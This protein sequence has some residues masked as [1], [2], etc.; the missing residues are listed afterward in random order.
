MIL[1]EN[2][3]GKLTSCI[4]FGYSGNY[5]HHEKHTIQ[6]ISCQCIQCISCQW[7]QYK[8][9][10]LLTIFFLFPS[11]VHPLLPF[12]SSA[13]LSEATLISSPVVL[14]QVFHQRDS[15][16]AF[17]HPTFAFPYLLY[18]G[19]FASGLNWEWFW[20]KSKQDHQDQWATVRSF[21]AAFW[22]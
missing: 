11:S 10:A 1:T 22:C 18:W 14:L 20:Y 5:T 19:W 2:L 6:C 9:L 3:K 16:E 17:P 15:C 12:S 21:S 13:E 4:F 8:K 7:K